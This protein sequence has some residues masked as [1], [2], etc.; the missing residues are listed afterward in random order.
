[1]VLADLV[2]KTRASLAPAWDPRVGMT[3]V[4][5]EADSGV[6]TL[7]GTADA[8]GKC[9]AAEDV[10]RSLAGVVRVVN[11]MECVPGSPD[12]TAEHV[13][14]QFL[15]NLSDERA[16]LAGGTALA[17]ADYPR[18]ALWM[19]DKFPLPDTVQVND[20]ERSGSDTV[21]DAIAR[22]A[23]LLDVPDTLVAFETIRQAESVL[24]S[25]CRTAPTTGES[26]LV[27]TP[28]VTDVSAAA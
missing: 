14:A 9:R 1:M 17:R 12:E 10:A 4:G 23:S 7:A 15:R 16:R 3:V 28:L 24:E 18:W 22:I 13:R 8:P 11:L 21:E 2:L 26:E 6:V 19:T 27:A 5:I 25:P 20:R